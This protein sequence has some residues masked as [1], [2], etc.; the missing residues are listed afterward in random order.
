MA[1]AVYIG[2]QYRMIEKISREGNMAS[3]YRCKDD[4]DN[5]YAIKLF[6]KYEGNDDMK[7]YQQRSFSREVETLKRAQHE[8]IVK[9]FE[10]DL[11]DDL[12]KFY[13]VLEYIKGRNFNEAF[14]D[15]CG[16]DEFEKL[17]LMDKVLAGVE[18]L[19]KKG[20]IHRDLKPSNIMI[21]EE[22]IVKII[23]F[24]ISKITDSFYSEY[25]VG[26]FST[27]RFRSPEQTQGK[28]ATFQ[29]DIYSLGLVFY[30]IFKKEKLTDDTVMDI[31]N[32]PEGIQ[33]I[34]SKMLKTEPAQ[35]YKN[36]TDIR[37]DIL[38]IQSMIKQ[39]RFLTL[40][41]TNNVS[42]LLFQYGYIQRDEIAFAAV[43]IKKDFEGRTFAECHRDAETGNFSYNFYG[44]QYNVICRRDNYNS[45][46]LTIVHIR[47]ISSADLLSKKESAYEVPYRID[48]KASASNIMSSNE[49][50]ANTLIDELMAFEVEKE[51]EKAESLKTKD[52]A[53]KWESILELQRKKIDK[54][55]STLGY[56][57]FKV[58]EKDN[59]VEVYLTKEEIA[60][61][62]KFGPDDMLRMTTKK[63]DNIEADVGYLR[64]YHRG[65]LTIDLAANAYIDNIASVGVIC[66]NKNLQE[67]A[68]KRQRQALKNVRFRENAN[69][70]ISEIIFDPKK[71][72]SKNNELLTKNACHSKYIDDSKL[73]SLEK[74]LASDD[75]FLLQGPPG[76][77]KTTF[78]SELVY[79]ILDRKPDSKILIASQSHVAVDHSLTKIKEAMPD[80]QLIRIGI[81]EKM[82]DAISNYTLDAFRKV[83]IQNVIERCVQALQ[84]YKKEIGLDDSLQEQNTIILEI[85]H[86]IKTV[87]SLEDE[88]E[89]V[90]AEKEKIDIMNGKWSFVNETI[91]N[92]KAMVRTKTNSV[93][94]DELTHIIDSFT[95]DL[96][97]LNG[98]LG[99]LLEES[100]QLSEQKEALD[101]KLWQLMSLKE[102]KEKDILD[103][104]EML[105]VS[106]DE[107]FK[108]K[109][110]EI[111]NL[112][113]EGQS[114]YNRYAK[115]EGLCKEWMSRV[116]LGDGLLQESLM[117][118]SIVGATCLGIASLSVNVDMKF[119]WVIVDEAGKATPTEILVPISLGKKIVLVGDH[120][121]L[122]PVVDETLLEEDQTNTI[123]K[124]DLETSLFE[125][126]EGALNED[127]KSILS[128]QYR[129]NPVIG[130][131]IS[132]L[133][134]DGT[135]ESKTKKEE[136]TIPL[137]MYD[138]KSLVWL[139]TSKR[140]D[141]AEE[142]IG[143]TFRNRCEAKI[144]F[145]QLLEIEAELAEL[146]Q[147]KEVGIIAGYR[148]QKEELRRLYESQYR[149]RFHY[150]KDVDINTVD[151]FQGRETDIIFYSVVR[152]NNEGKLGF[153][154]DVRRLNVAFSRAREL[155]VVVGNHHS[156]T[157]NITL[158]NE[159]NPFVGIVTYIYDHEEDC[160]LKEVE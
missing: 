32:L 12:N 2:D 47:F 42:K 3:V 97:N 88:L 23:D 76:T 62:I 79:Q 117:D 34:L 11:D 114:Q 130:N 15:I 16:Y 50:G 55:K 10:H 38:H 145:E 120:K 116:K 90:E 101:K 105:G 84:E 159:P 119:D 102:G 139:S 71:A 154:Q 77:G 72:T 124:K 151:A 70:M 85:E 75:F 53:T 147:Y 134:Y 6:D 68:I 31:S 54:E 58:N 9:I 17:E 156:V 7:D 18:Y 80:V 96:T 81:K 144:I 136:K 133:F 14:N 49:I 44:K 83:W 5:E 19:H 27:P 91:S 29:S 63:N 28:D 24:G 95:S 150:V 123:D 40:G 98:R 148:E 155:L 109:K 39:T 146:K 41:I 115:V 82:S 69:P 57:G 135:L 103:W 65:V 87:S 4:F 110:K 64:D 86:L 93:T 138:N 157:K 112:I 43:A 100:I 128:Q 74:A 106:S 37:N 113:K 107:E 158:H 46:R 142:R 152:S 108:Q 149:E 36:V 45:N 131:L 20:I 13:I 137:K 153:L 104:K 33:N 160:L 129:M 78:I 125:Y 92:M 132:E 126:M 52:M 60:D 21:N 141:N 127:C 66:I 73:K 61:N 118:A 94:E 35:R 121:Q 99:D 111:Q 48:V 8:N 1:R 26:F 140:K 122:P 25:T 22:G 67:I 89:E 51:E 143:K 56:S 59:S 30:E